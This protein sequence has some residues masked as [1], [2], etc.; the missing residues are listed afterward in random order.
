M[1][2]GPRS[3]RGFTLLEML[4]ALTVLAIAL[5]AALRASS[6]GVQNTAEIRNRLL[7]G[8]V[9]QNRLAEH[10][11]RRD[12]LPVGVAQGDESQGGVH[13]RWEEKIV[14]TPNFQFRRIEIRVSME[15]EPDLTLGRLT[16]FM[17]RPGG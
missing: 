12:W 10:L 11:A 7:A 8:W 14:G 4:V 6:A 3:I 17:V 15:Q 1:N 16:G 2:P 5:L 9:A 13:F